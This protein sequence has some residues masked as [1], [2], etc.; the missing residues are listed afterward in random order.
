V[1][2]HDTRISTVPVL[3]PSKCVTPRYTNID[4]ARPAPVQ[5]PSCV[6]SVSVDFIKNASAH[7]FAL[8]PLP[9]LT[10]EVT[11]VD[12][13]LTPSDMLNVEHMDSKCYA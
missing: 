10:F 4:G 12:L 11:V 9:Y 2:H 13:E 3:R 5:C 1:S 8:A 6:R 7:K